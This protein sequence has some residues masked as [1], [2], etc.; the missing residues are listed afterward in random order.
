MNEEDQRRTV[1]IALLP[2]VDVTHVSLELR[3]VC[4][5]LIQHLGSHHRADQCSSNRVF[6]PPDQLPIAAGIHPKIVSERLGHASI[7]ITLDTYS[8]VLPGLQEAAAERFDRMLEGSSSKLDGGGDVGKML[9]DRV[10]SKS[11]PGGTRT[12]DA[13]IKR[14]LA[15][16]GVAP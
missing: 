2:A 15:L 4:Q 3:H 16:S 14:Y 8:H 7:G 13:L 1:A 11:E 12:R 5:Q 6:E 9:A 10:Q